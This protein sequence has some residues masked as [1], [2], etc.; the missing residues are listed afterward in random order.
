MAEIVADHCP[1]CN[2]A[3]IT[4]RVDACHH[5]ST[6][7]DWQ[8][9]YELFCVCRACK[10]GSILKVSDKEASDYERTH[11]VGLLKA[12]LALN[13]YVDIAGSVTINDRAVM[14]PPEG[15][16]DNVKSVFMEG[17]KSLTVGCPNA[18]AT[19]FRL[20]LDLVTRDHL[21]PEDEVHS[22]LNHKVRRDLGL[23]LPWL[24]EAQRLPSDLR[25]M[26]HCVKEDG[27]DGAHVGTLQTADAEDLQ[28]FVRLLLE[29]LY[30]EKVRLEAADARRAARRAPPP[31]KRN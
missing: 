15:L 26:S 5:I 27:N 6:H 8:W 23:R 7:R 9:Y 4:L 28:D 29:R 14:E 3:H 13:H 17:A 21:P 18:A 22:G 20:C 11:R 10:R 1:R 25:R 30:T 12:D 16:P 2:A 24:F 31:N 19:M